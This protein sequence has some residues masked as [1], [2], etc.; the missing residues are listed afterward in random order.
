MFSLDSRSLAEWLLMQVTLWGNGLLEVSPASFIEIILCLC[1]L[2]GASRQLLAGLLYIFKKC[3][4]VEVV[5]V[6]VL[7][8][9]S[10][11]CLSERWQS[12][13][14]GYYFCREASRQT[15]HSS[16]LIFSRWPK[17]GLLCAAPPLLISFHSWDGRDDDRSWESNPAA[18]W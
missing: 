18:L 13:E 14:R 15:P 6:D 16:L 5:K 12:E 8:K 7:S 17:F 9:C 4:G 10:N 2:C 3:C 1:H 11:V